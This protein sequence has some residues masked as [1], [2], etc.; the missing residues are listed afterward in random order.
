MKKTWNNHIELLN[1][2]QG[3][4][5]FSYED[6]FIARFMARMQ[7]DSYQSFYKLLVKLYKTCQ[8]LELKYNVRYKITLNSGET[9]VFKAIKNSKR[10]A[11]IIPI[12][13]M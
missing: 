3:D 6:H 7:D 10:K 4:Y 1:D 5:W 13:I 12:T 9:V 2:V 11:K 8:K